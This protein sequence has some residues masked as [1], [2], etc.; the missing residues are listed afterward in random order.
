VN[1]E[2][3]A[4]IRPEHIRRAARTKLRSD[5][6]DEFFDMREV[7]KEEMATN[8]KWIDSV[9]WEEEGDTYHLAAA[10]VD[11]VRRGD[12]NEAIA[13]AARYADIDTM[14]EVDEND[15]LVDEDGRTHEVGDG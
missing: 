6:F 9:I 7:H 10:I 1:T 4:G 15:L 5:W 3:P 12:E 14:F 8:P 2:P 11:R 13:E